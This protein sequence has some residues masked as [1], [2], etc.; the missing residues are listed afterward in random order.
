MARWSQQALW[1]G[2]RRWRRR[3]P[4][5][6]DHSA[7]LYAN[8]LERKLAAL[9]EALRMEQLAHEATRS[10][11]SKGAEKET[12]MLRA[13]VRELQNVLAEAMKANSWV[14]CRQLLYH[15]SCRYLP[16]AATHGKLLPPGMRKKASVGVGGM[17]TGRLS[18]GTD[19]IGTSAS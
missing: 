12:A 11:S 14:A 18:A 6:I 17:L 1:H 19:I 4:P 5:T 10:D 15:E 7:E 8:D 13:L 3:C 2:L 16:E 9:A